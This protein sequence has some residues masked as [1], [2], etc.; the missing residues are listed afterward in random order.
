MLSLFTPDTHNALLL[1]AEQ[2]EQLRVQWPSPGFSRWL[3]REGQTDALPAQRSYRELRTAL[4]GEHA[5][6]L[7]PTLDTVR[8]VTGT[9]L[10][11]WLQHTR[12]PNNGALVIVG[13][14]DVDDVSRS[15]E[16]LLRGWKGDGT[17]VPA[18]PGPPPVRVERRAGP[19]FLFTRDAR[20]RTTEV[21]FGC[22]LPPIKTF[23]AGVR[24]EALARLF[25]DDLLHGLRF[26]LG[27]SYSPNVRAFTLRGGTAV[28]EGVLD[29]ADPALPEALEMLHGWL[30]PTRPIPL[31]PAAL[32]SERRNMAR[33][34][35]F[36]DSINGSVAVDLFHAW[37]QGWPLTGLEEF[38][39]ALA[40]MT[41]G[42][43]TADLEKC[44]ASAVV[45]ILGNSAPPSGIN[46]ASSRESIPVQR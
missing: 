43:L 11:R 12:R 9:Q 46:S 44:R 25:R 34:G 26:K 23:A 20:R 19:Q 29:V 32:E 31:K 28:L 2:P 13:D 30:D 45:S 24:S 35:V 40:R 10:Q 21:R 36:Q 22:L 39:D 41:V 14:V 5:Y 42:D 37:N 33:R 6:R 16:E 8:T 17:P 4:F 38:P 3:E 27:A 7:A 1:I 18:P 15:A